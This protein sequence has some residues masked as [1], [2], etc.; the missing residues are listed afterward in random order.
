LRPFENRIAD[1][2]RALAAKYMV[3]HRA[4]MAMTPF[5]RAASGLDGALNRGH[6]QAAVMGLR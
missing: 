6:R 4:R 3:D 2:R 1:L 5:R